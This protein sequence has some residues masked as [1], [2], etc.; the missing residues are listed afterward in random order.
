MKGNIKMRKVFFM[1]NSN[2][3]VYENGSG[4]E[5]AGRIPRQS[6]VSMAV[7][8]AVMLLPVGQA[9]AYN[10]A[11]G[12]STGTSVASSAGSATSGGVSPATAGSDGSLNNEAFG[13]SS[14]ANGGAA[15]S[16]GNAATA[17]G[18]NATSVGGSSNAAGANA[19]A[20]GGGANANGANTTALGAQASANGANSIAIGSTSSAT[21]VGSIAAGANAIANGGGWLVRDCGRQWS[22]RDDV[23]CGERVADCDWRCVQ[24]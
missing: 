8:A 9:Y 20:Y 23:R 19:V 4:K 1:G 16:I 14:T 5:A 22:G 2:S 15:V 7:L 13:I 17:T 11:S 10:Y 12:G 21:G 6:K 18:A 3:E 24:G